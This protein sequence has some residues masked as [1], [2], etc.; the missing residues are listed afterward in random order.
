V[1]PC[2]TPGTAPRQIGDDLVEHLIG[3]ITLETAIFVDATN[4]DPKQSSGR[5]R[6]MRPSHQWLDSAGKTSDS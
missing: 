2:F 5:N 4:E 1:D 6:Q 3:V